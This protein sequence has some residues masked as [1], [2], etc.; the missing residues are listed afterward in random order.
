MPHHD[1]TVISF[2][3]SL[4]L[5]ADMILFFML[6]NF[7]VVM[8]FGCYGVWHVFCR[9]G[10]RLIYWIGMIVLTFPSY[11]I[12]ATYMTR[13]ERVLFLLVL[14][15]NLVGAII[16][17]SKLHSLQSYTWYQRISI[18]FGYHEI[19]HVIT[20]LGTVSLYYVVDSLNQNSFE[21]RCLIQEEAWKDNYWLF[22]WKELIVLFQITA[23][24][25]FCNS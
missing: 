10:Q 15:L 16:F 7:V 8:L 19:F 1:I 22:L 9:R 23:D 4:T 14:F 2:T 18:I 21:R 20:V 12:V 11:P 3:K 17:R 25:D 13:H 5:H 24:R 6:V